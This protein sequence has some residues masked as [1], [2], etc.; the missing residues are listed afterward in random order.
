MDAKFAQVASGPRG[1]TFGDMEK[2]LQ[3]YPDH[4]FYFD[5]DAGEIVA[6]HRITGYEHLASPSY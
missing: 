5:A 3:A 4:H 1:V 6:V 2:A